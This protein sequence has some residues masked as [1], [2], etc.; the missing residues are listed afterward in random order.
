MTNYNKFWKLALEDSIHD[1]WKERK[2]KTID[3]DEEIDE[4]KMINLHNFLI[5]KGSNLLNKP[6]LTTM[7]QLLGELTNNTVTSPTSEYER[8]IERYYETKSPLKNELFFDT[9]ERIT[10]GEIIRAWDEWDKQGQLPPL[11]LNYNNKAGFQNV[12]DIYFG[13]DTEYPS[14][15]LIQSRQKDKIIGNFILNYMF[16]EFTLKNNI[17]YL[18]FDANAGLI[19]KIFRSFDNIFNLVL[20]SSL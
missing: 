15:G 5:K 1:F 17:G 13:N 19:G 10:Y 2:T 16:P 9:K 11:W 3:D 18:T 20:T 6:N 14:F 12:L 7:Q 4:D 8:S